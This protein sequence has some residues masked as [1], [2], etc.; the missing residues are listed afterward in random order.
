[1]SQSYIE[2][3]EKILGKFTHL[4]RRLYVAAFN[5][6]G[7]YWMYK[8]IFVMQST[9]WEHYALWFFAMISHYYYILDNRKKLNMEDYH[10]GAE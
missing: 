2:T 4:M 7:W 9:D 10:K 6:Y 3:K 5:L 1:M 8:L